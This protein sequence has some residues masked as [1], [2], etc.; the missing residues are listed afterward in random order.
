[1]NFAYRIF[2]IMAFTLQIGLGGPVDTFAALGCNELRCSLKSQEVGTFQFTAAGALMDGDALAAEGTICTVADGGTAI[3][4]GRLFIN[5][6][7]SAATEGIAYELRDGW[8]DFTKNVFQQQWNRVQSYDEAGVPTLAAQYSSHCLLGVD[9]EQNPQVN[10][11]VLGELLQWALM[12]GC[13]FQPGTLDASLVAPVPIDD[14]HDLPISECIK[15]MLR[16]SPDAVT[17]FDYTQDPPSFNVTRR[18]QCAVV[19]LPFVG[20]VKA[21]KIAARPDLQ[22]GHILLRFEQPNK[23]DGEPATVIIVDDYPP[24]T[25]GLEWG[26]FVSTI[27][28]AGGNAAYQKNAVVTLPIPVDYSGAG[29]EDSAAIPFLEKCLPWTKQYDDSLVVTSISTTVDAGQVDSAGNALETDAALYPRLLVSGDV[30]ADMGLLAA[31]L[32]VTVGFTYTGSNGTVSQ[33]LNVVGTNAVTRTYSRLSSY[34]QAEAAPSGLAEILY[35]AYSVLLY[36]GSYTS[37]ANEAAPVRLGMV[38]NLTGGRGE[39]AAMNALV[40]GIDLNLDNGETTYHFGPGGRLTIQDLM[41]QL[42]A[43][44]TRTVSSH[45]AERATGQPSAVTVNGPY[46]GCAQNNPQAPA[47]APADGPFAVNDASG[48]SSLAVAFNSYSY[49]FKSPSL[50]DTATIG[51]LDT[52][53]LAVAVGDYIIL[54]IDYNDDLTLDGD[55]SIY[56]ASSWPADDGVSQYDV[57]SSGDQPYIDIWWVPVAKIVSVDDDTPGTYFQSTDGTAKGKIVQLLNTHLIL[58]TWAVDG[59]AVNVPSAWTGVSS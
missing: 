15:K 12:V 8:F 52:S 54:E 5:R 58:T 25:S 48:E 10:G 50:S 35:E 51:G 32:T 53:G 39:W 13:Y 31:R 6:S 38:M 36:E 4:C 47:A 20:E 45:I 56:A 18:A 46:A 1:M 42:R 2:L 33:V 26:A 9:L 49:L 22:C 43:Q 16:L 29:D 30:T 7:G 27:E 34:T 3:F 23:V 24:G 37:L 14:V 41:E 28:L 19:D 44:R 55:P 11:Q 40:E 57:D 17:W 59:M 21:Q